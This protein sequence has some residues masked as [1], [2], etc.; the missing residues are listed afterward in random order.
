[1][2]SLLNGNCTASNIPYAGKKVTIQSWTSLPKEWLKYKT[3]ASKNRMNN[4]TAI[5]YIC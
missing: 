5:S 4:E 1:M 2:K 3:D